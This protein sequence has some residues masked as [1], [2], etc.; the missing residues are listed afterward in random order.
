MRELRLDGGVCKGRGAERL[1][2]VADRVLK[3]MELQQV[4]DVEEETAIHGAL[5][6]HR[7]GKGEICGLE[8]NL[9]GQ[10]HSRDLAVA[11]R[12]R[13]EGFC[14]MVQKQGDWETRAGD[15]G[16]SGGQARVEMVSGRLRAVGKANKGKCKSDEGNAGM[17]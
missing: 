2:C 10:G 16:P 6:V 15:C 17:S 11:R 5:E 4:R 7:Y 3:L 12:S 8:E 13:S 1:E 14:L 9:T